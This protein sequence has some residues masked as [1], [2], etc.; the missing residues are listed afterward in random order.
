MEQQTIDLVQASWA[1]VLP[2][3]AT[4]GARFYRNLF[5]ADPSL[6]VLF[7]GDID[8]QAA[9][10]MQMIGTA[11]GKLGD[12]DSLVPVLRQLGER[13]AGYGVHPNHYQVVG[14]SLLK[15]LEQGLGPAFTPATKEAWT[16]AYAVMSKVMIDAAAR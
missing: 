2:I 16:A 11:V 13:H 3:S 5:E 8:A 1:K 14:S 4:A 7:K 12:L 10:L 6:R 15:T 9:K